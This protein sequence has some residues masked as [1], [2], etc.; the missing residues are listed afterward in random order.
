[1]A[2]SRPK[3][4]VPKVVG[5]GNHQTENPLGCDVLRNKFHLAKLPVV[6][7]WFLWVCLKR[8]HKWGVEADVSMGRRVNNT[9][10]AELHFNVINTR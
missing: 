5:A 3:T 7:D 2:P 6:V 8:L 1:M 10:G 9:F 4:R